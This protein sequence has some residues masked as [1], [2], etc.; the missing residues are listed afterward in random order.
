[1]LRE[2]TGKLFQLTAQLYKTLFLNFS[3]VGLINSKTGVSWRQ[4]RIS[5]ILRC[6]ISVFIL[7]ITFV[8]CTTLLIRSIGIWTDWC[9]ISK[10]VYMAAIREQL[11]C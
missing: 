8:K 10:G 2:F 9:N 5:L 6:S 3:Q 11:C 1:M 4:V 7:N